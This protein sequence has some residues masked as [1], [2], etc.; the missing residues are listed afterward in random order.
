[1]LG[2]RYATGVI[3]T[4]RVPPRRELLELRPGL[5][6][7][8]GPPRTGRAPDY[9]SLEGYLNGLVLAK[10]LQRAGSELDTERLVA[11]FEGLGEL[12]LGTGTPIR[13]DASEHQGS[14]KVWGTRIAESGSYELLDRE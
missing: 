4:Q 10:A 6:G 11:A 13:F 3:V 7:S 9:V 1:L 8:A 14:H 12:D 2:P 5:Q